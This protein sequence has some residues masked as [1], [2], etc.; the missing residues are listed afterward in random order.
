[1]SRK[2]KGVMYLL[3]Y[4]S[5]F[6]SGTKAWSCTVQDKSKPRYRDICCPFFFIVLE[7]STNCFAKLCRISATESSNITVTLC[8]KEKRSVN[9]AKAK[10]MADH[11]AR[12]A[13]TKAKNIYDKC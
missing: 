9:L 12:S 6:G 1:M 4:A 3:R 11:R 5:V 13:I 2:Q 10:Q 8:H 7:S